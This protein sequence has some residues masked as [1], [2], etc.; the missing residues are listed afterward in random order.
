MVTY[1]ALGSLPQPPINA[2]DVEPVP[3]ALVGSADTVLIGGVSCACGALL[4]QGQLADATDRS[5][6]LGGV[7]A[8]GVQLMKSHL[9]GGTGSNGRG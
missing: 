1:G 9:G 7:E 2:M 4:L 6:A 8:D 5:S 3:A